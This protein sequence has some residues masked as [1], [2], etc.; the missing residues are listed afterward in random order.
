MSEDSTSD[1]GDDRNLQGTTSRRRLLKA[2][3]FIAGAGTFGLG[4][5][6][7]MARAAGKDS[8]DSQPQR[9]N[10]GEKGGSPLPGPPVLYEPLASAPQLE[11]TGNWEAD[12]LMVSGADAYVNGEYLFQDFVYDDFG[13]NTAAAPEPPSPHPDHHDFGPMTG[14]IVSPTDPV[15]AN[16]AADLLEFR[17]RTTDVGVAYR[18]TLNTMQAP[19]LAG[20]AI[21]IDRD[22]EGG[23]TDWG[24]GLGDLG[25]PADHVLVTWG[26]GAELD[27]KPLADNRVSV[28]TRRNQIELEVPLNPDEVTWRHYLVVGLFD[29]EKKQFKQIQ[30]QPTKDQP[31]GAHGQNPP[32]VFNVGFRYYD[33]EPLGA[34]NTEPGQAGREFDQTLRERTGSRGIGYGH[35]REDAQARALAGRNISEFHTEI[36]FGKLRAGTT[37][38]NVPQTGYINRLY[39]SHHDLGEGIGPYTTESG[40]DSNG[41]DVLRGQI[42]PYSVYVPESYD[43]SQTPFH[44]HLHSLSG[45]YNQYAAWTPDF[46]RQVGEQHETIIMTTTGRGPGVP[47]RDQAELDLFEAWADAAAHYNIDFDHVTLGG[48]SMG[49]IGTHQIASKWPDLFACAFPIVGSIGGEN[50][51]RVAGDDLYT[52]NE[53][54][55]VNQRHVP[56]LMWQGTTDE[57]V[58]YPLVL[59]YEQHLNDLGLR[60]E[61]D[62]F[63]GYDHL[64]FGY[65]DEWGPAA[66]FLEGA[67]VTRTPPR[68]TYRRVPQLD[69]DDLGLIHDHVYWISDIVVGDGTDNGLVDVRSLGFGEAEP[70]VQRYRREGTNPAPHVKRGIEWKEPVIDPQPQ[71]ALNLDLTDIESVT[72]WVEEA[73]LD[74]SEPIRLVVDSNRAVT[75]TLAASCET[76]IVEVPA[77]HS[78][79]LV[80]VCG[81]ADIRKR[82]SW[83]V[84]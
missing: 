44:I 18:I 6:G 51:D 22:T 73:N 5:T 48:Y 13:A 42:I 49:G 54:I 30:E 66:A 7:S 12:P 21:G 16:N 38:R 28:D 69:N 63:P 40:D 71:N 50:T 17:T 61:L 25:A 59:K 39:A 14:D 23:Q 72:I 58:P 79:R 57:L 60:H 83:V 2:T 62:T 15:Y 84:H 33:Q 19:D 4:S 36:D 82:T 77:G 55:A 20:I 31:G 70:I 41:E 34:T 64:A 74:A 81:R 52:N 78:E 53:L 47:Y 80:R 8:A 1:D 37:E 3:S 56:L 43:G 24:Y 45:G 35:W 29:T 76:H 32:P 27:G 68:I 10:P 75:L 46:I 9:H 65:R 67:T 11:N 26:T